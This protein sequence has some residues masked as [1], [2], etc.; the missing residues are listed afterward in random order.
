[1]ICNICYIDVEYT[2]YN[3]SLWIAQRGIFIALYQK[4]HRQIAQSVPSC[5]AQEYEIFLIFR[6]IPRN[7]GAW[8]SRKA[9]N[10]PGWR[11]EGGF[12]RHSQP[13][14][15]ILENPY[16]GARHEGTLCAICRN[17][18]LHLFNFFPLASIIKLVYS[19]SR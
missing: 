6:S 4:V 13:N 9:R 11:I 12:V 16:A 14:R 19:G 8:M 2:Y 7:F 18:S 5:H 3:A 1:M 10:E 17:I 15:N